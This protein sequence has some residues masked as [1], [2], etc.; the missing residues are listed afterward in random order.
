MITKEKNRKILKKGFSMSILLAVMMLF[1]FSVNSQ[2]HEKRK[3]SKGHD[4][5][6]KTHAKKEKKGHDKDAKRVEMR[7]AH[8]RDRGEGGKGEE[9]ATQLGKYETYNVVKRGVRLVLKYNKRT[10]SFEGTMRNTT[11]RTIQKARVEVHLSNGTELG[12]TVPVNLKRNS[13]KR[14]VLKATKK[15]FK[16]WSTH[17]EVGGNEHGGKSKE[18]KEK[19]GE[20]HGKEGKGEH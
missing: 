19:R 10:N 13:T 7:E 17:A 2:E 5:D 12:P 18:G 15:G 16:T 14:V 11:N 1:S 20:G 8:L 9:D 6:S 3:E 4:K